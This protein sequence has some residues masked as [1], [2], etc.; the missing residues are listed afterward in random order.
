MGF[1]SGPQGN[2]HCIFDSIVWTP[3][4][5]AADPTD[6]DFMTMASLPNSP[7]GRRF[8]PLRVATT[9]GVNIFLNKH[10]HMRRLIYL[11]SFLELNHINIQSKLLNSEWNAA[12]SRR[13]VTSNFKLQASSSAIPPNLNGNRSP[14]QSHLSPTQR[15]SQPFTL[16]HNTAALFSNRGVFMDRGF[17][18]LGALCCHCD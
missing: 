6:P 15:S 16:Q 4:T 12:E 9:T 14:H 2:N 1:R 5:W 10:L 17:H 8:H 7:R 3:R 13:L 18:L 11:L